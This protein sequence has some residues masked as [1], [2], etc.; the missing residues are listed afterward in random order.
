[1][2]NSQSLTVGWI[3]SHGVAA[4]SNEINYAVLLQRI[5]HRNE[6]LKRKQPL[7]APSLQLPGVPATGLRRWGG[8]AQEGKTAEAKNRCVSLLCGSH[9]H[10]T[11]NQPMAST[12][13]GK[14]SSKKQTGAQ[15]I[16]LSE[17][18]NPGFGPFQ[19]PTFCSYV[20]C[21]LS[22]T[23]HLA[24]APPGGYTPGGT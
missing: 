11:T 2:H 14:S 16:A 1:M 8:R 10:G 17:P 18:F 6:K 12:R 24:C 13:S 7:R 19:T 4:E 21:F 22:V 23:S 3:S 9:R 15:K 20:I 5:T